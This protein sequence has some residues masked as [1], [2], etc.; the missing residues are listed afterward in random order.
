MSSIFSK[1]VAGD[2]PCHKIAETE[3]CL[4]FLD[5]SPLKRGHTLCIPKQ[6]VNYLYDLDDDLLSE[7]TLFSKSIAKAIQATIPCNRIG[8]AVIG[9]EV[10]HAHVHLIPI[11]KM[12]DMNFANPKLSISHEELAVIAEK[13]RANL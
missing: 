13:I 9:L 12:G 10:P 2:I 6:E 4:A 7:L 3:N 5:I 1:I 11:E 8:I